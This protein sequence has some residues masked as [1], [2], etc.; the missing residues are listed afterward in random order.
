MA[1]VSEP[2]LLL[3]G[4]KN[5]TLSI[6]RNAGESWEPLS[7]PRQY[8]TMLH[9]LAI[10]PKNASLFYAAIASASGSGLYRSRDAGKTWQAVEGLGAP[11]VYSLAFWSGDS[12]V[13]AAGLRTGVTLSRDG[14][15]TWKAISPADNIELQP[16]VSVAFDPTNAAVIYAGTPRLPWKTTNSGATWKLIAEGM[17]TDSDIITVRVDPRQPSRVF[18]GACSGFWRSRDGGGVWAKMQ[19]IPFSSRRTYAFAQ[20]PDHT[21]TI[22]A[23]TSR[24]LYRTLDGGG[25]WKEIAEHEV[26]SLAISNGTLY[27]ATADAGLFKSVDDGATLQPI[28]QGFVSRNFAQIGG[29]GDHLYTGSNFDAD[30]GTFFTSVD[31]GRHW[32]PIG[33]GEALGNESVVAVTRSAAGTL[34]AASGNSVFRSTD[35]GKTWERVL[36]EIAPQPVSKSRSARLSRVPAR[37]AA[38][39]ATARS[40]GFTTLCA[41]EGAILAGTDSEILRSTDEGRTWAK[42]ASTR[43]PVRSLLASDFVVAALPDSLLVS[44]DQGVTWSSRHT[45]F[46]T[47]VYNLAAARRVLLAGTSRGLF[48]SEDGGETWHAAKSGLPAASITAVAV[49]SATGTQAFAYAYGNVYQSHDAGRTWQGY[50]QEGLG[51]ASVRSFAIAAP[52][53][54]NLLAVT[55]TRGIFLRDLDENAVPPSNISAVDLRKDRY[56]PNQQNDK[57]PAF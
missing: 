17:S 9:T 4:T 20:D 21:N 19:G 39:P 36:P 34:I 25:A 14:G 13:I 56:V 5:A 31:G 50:D 24:G 18:I 37:I 51:G 46:F 29:S 1:S 43:N 54:H 35:D 3:A 32:G 57:S 10:D 53:P 16:V 55:A 48:R 52:G 30:A 28:D 22:F 38:K 11:E 2:H 23:G 26:K 33:G 49:D 45:P 47:E 42:V 40:T 8:V 44:S 41:V 7:F 15:T 12:N 6:S 27:V